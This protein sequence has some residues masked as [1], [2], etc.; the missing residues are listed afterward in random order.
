[1]SEEPA[2]AAES[3]RQFVADL[4]NKDDSTPASQPMNAF[5]FVRGR[6][7]LTCSPFTA[8]SP[9]DG[10]LQRAQEFLTCSTGRLGFAEQLMAVQNPGIA[11]VV[12]LDGFDA[13]YVPGWDCHGLPIE[14]QV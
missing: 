14:L 10:Q 12:S 3:T 5:L 2:P 4:P 13:P 6:M 1:M 8:R 9:L 7:F 11:I